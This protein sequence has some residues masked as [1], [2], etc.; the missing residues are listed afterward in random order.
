[1]ATW[2]GSSTKYTLNGDYLN[3]NTKDGPISLGPVGS[4]QKNHYYDVTLGKNGGTLNLTMPVADYRGNRYIFTINSDVGRSIRLNFNNQSA[5]V[6]TIVQTY[7]RANNRTIISIKIG[8]LNYGEVQYFIPG[9]PFG[10]STSSRSHTL[11][12]GESWSLGGIVCFLAGALIRTP[13]GAMPVERLKAGDEVCVWNPEKQKTEI[14]TLTWSGVGKAA[15][16]SAA[17]DDLAGWPIRICKDAIKQGVPSR[18]LLITS[19]HCLF[20]QGVFVPARMLV[21][22]LSIIYDKTIRQ[23]D[24]YHL[25]SADHAVIWANDLMTESY[26]DTGNRSGFEPAGKV[27]S[28]GKGPFNWARD[29]AAPLVTERKRVEPIFSRLALRA[30][31]MGLSTR[32]PT[33]CLSKDPELHL[34]TEDGQIIRAVRTRNARSIFMIP[35]EVTM[36]KI[37]SRTSRPFDTFGPF[38]DDRRSLGVLLGEITFFETRNTRVLDQHLQ[39]SDLAGWADLEGKESRWT[40]GEATLCLD[41]EALHGFGVLALEVLSAGPYLGEEAVTN[42]PPVVLALRA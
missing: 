5:A 2:N 16:N 7:D 1:M 13:N 3:I 31:D 12:K 37:C 42:E 35:P 19:D 4:S 11:A 9:N 10:L 40:T 34:R 29:S 39:M 41:R 8:I 27:V 26:L 17:S 33:R 36:L 15:V 21:N 18:D 20:I 28:L 23:F 32:S 24:F 25:E 38:V 30:Q 14:R 6:K 22:G